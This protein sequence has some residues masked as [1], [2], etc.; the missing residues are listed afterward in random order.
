[1]HPTEALTNELRTHVTPIVS[2][3]S[4]RDTDSDQIV[5]HERGLEAQVFVLDGRAAIKRME[6]NVTVRSKK[7]PDGRCLAE[8][9]LE[10]LTFNARKLANIDF[11]RSEPRTSTPSH[12]GRDER[13]RE[14][15]QFRV[16]VEYLER[17][18]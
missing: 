17:T 2:I 4:L 15:F 5:L 18:E 7:Y 16:V 10:Q 3:G 9:A 8:L 13:G 11:V 1:M 6:L 14:T 12:F